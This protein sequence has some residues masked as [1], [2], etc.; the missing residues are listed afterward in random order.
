MSSVKIGNIDSLETLGKK[1]EQTIGAGIVSPVPVR[2]VNHGFTALSLCCG[3]ERFEIPSRFS[4]DGKEG[5][6]FSV[7]GSTLLLMF[8]RAM[9][10]GRMLNIN[11]I[12]EAT[13]ESAPAQADEKEQASEEAAA[14]SATAPAAPRR[15]GRKPRAKQVTQTKSED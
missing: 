6:T 8:Y 15:R 10:M 13:A 7:D 4:E 2:F 3:S 1:V 11:E 14:V 9:Q 5:V 12:L